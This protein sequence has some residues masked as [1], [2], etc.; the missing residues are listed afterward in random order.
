M[1][2]S[3]LACDKLLSK[4]FPFILRGSYRESAKIA[5]D[6]G[7]EGIE[8]QIQDPQNYNSKELK[9][10]FEDYSIEV[11][12]IS[13]GLSFIFEGYSMTSNDRD[14]RDKTIERLK[15]I[16]DMSKVLNT[17]TLIG[18]IRGRM[19]ADE[20]EKDYEEKLSE[21]MYKLLEYAEYIESPIVF[22]Q[23][24][25][26]DGDVYNTTEDTIDFIKKFNSKYLFY[27]GDTYHMITEDKDISSAIKY[28][29]DYLSLFHISDYER[30]LP[31]DKHF[32]FKITADALKE[33]NYTG[34]VS[35]ECKPLPSSLEAAQIG[36][37][38]LQGLLGD[39]R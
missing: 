1:K 22:E 33:I 28:S 26:N 23:I 38:Y 13:T 21:S 35:L 19:Y 20:N 18:F 14:I 24:N 4:D 2:F 32:N 25:R 34:W 17:Q 6:I 29:K 37:N 31:D 9:K 16:M 12:A 27:N 3:I 5:S 8:L 30:L 15:R 39:I 36:L 11:S 10:V 7:F